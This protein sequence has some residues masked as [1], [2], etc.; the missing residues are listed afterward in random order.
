MGAADAA[1]AVSAARVLARL[2]ELFAIGGGPGANR[3]GLSAA[4]EQACALAAGW[5]AEAGLE[6]SWDAAGNLAG[7]LRGTEPGLP[8]VWTG[9]HLDTV[10]AGG[11]YD[12]A[13]GVVAAIEAVARLPAADAPLPRTVAVVVF[14]DEEGWRFGHGLFGSRAR[15]G[16]L[17]PGE[18][19]A[20]DA[21]GTSVR[22]ALA[23]LGRGDPDRVLAGPPAPAPGAYVELHVEQ[24][25]VLA[26]AGAPLGVVTGIV[27]MAGYRVTFHG[28][29]GHAGTTPMGARSDA[30][31]AA[32]AFA[33]ELRSAAAGLDGAVATVG[34]VDVAPGAANVIPGR[35]EMT[36]DARV[37][38]SGT[39]AALCAAV[40]RTAPEVAAAEGCRADVA[41]SRL[42][43]APMAAPVRAVLA[44]AVRAAGAEPV[45][46]ASGAGHDAHSLASAG[47]PTGMLFARSLAG[48]VSHCP[49]E[50]TDAEAI[51]LAV[52]ALAHAL[53]ELARGPA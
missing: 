23:A 47:V 13:L 19:D 49:E 41:G 1:P 43:P 12:G 28:A 33:L 14:R 11:R 30:L 53:A 44:R 36:V 6:V 24:G 26:G 15:F 20:R 35:V 25:P 39:L 52:D 2:E 50:H 17:Q 21:G 45:E 40:E 46:L 5:M 3:P 42:E 51:A 4:E 22:E 18:L 38:D 31:C 29:A 9:S 27:G 10:P 37:L 8:E 32:A 34:D 16:L 7:R 48:G